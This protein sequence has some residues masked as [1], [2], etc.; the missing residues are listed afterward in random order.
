M[1]CTP[2]PAVLL[3]MAALSHA[4]WRE[5]EQDTLWG[6]GV[7][8]PSIPSS[9]RGTATLSASSRDPQPGDPGYPTKD[10]PMTCF[11]NEPWDACLV[12]CGGGLQYQKSR[13]NCPS[14]GS[15]QQ[16]RWRTCNLQQCGPVL[17]PQ[18]VRREKGALGTKE[19]FLEF[20]KFNPSYSDSHLQPDTYSVRLEKRNEGNS[21][22]GIHLDAS[23]TSMLINLNADGCGEGAEGKCKVGQP[24]GKPI[25]IEPGNEYRF[26][27]DPKFVSQGSAPPSFVKALLGPLASGGVEGGIGSSYIEDTTE[28]LFTTT[29]A[30]RT[31]ELG[32][33]PINWKV[34]NKLSFNRIPDPQPFLFAGRVRGVEPE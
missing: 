16:L 20:G 2:I 12:G 27:I 11:E 17:G 25:P 32:D 8:A 31:K 7:R 4:E 18:N 13:E 34:T 6:Q 21:W 33:T 5:A 1:G 24:D 14:A 22:S 10:I 15:A 9:L 29:C 26:L 30:C 28:V 23:K 3:F 19:A